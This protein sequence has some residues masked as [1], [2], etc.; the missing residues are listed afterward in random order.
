MVLH[1]NYNAG[2]LFDP[3]RYHQYRISLKNFID[4][5][6][7]TNGFMMMKSRIGLF[8]LCNSS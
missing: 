8:T 4:D 1:F 5:R 3:T 2:K 6:S 7:E